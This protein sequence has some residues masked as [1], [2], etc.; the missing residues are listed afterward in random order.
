[1]IFGRLCC[2]ALLSGAAALPQTQQPGNSPPDVAAQVAPELR[3]FLDVFSAVQTKAAGADGESL[4]HMIYEGAIPS[5]LRRLDPHTQFFEPTQF[6]QL[7]QMEASEEKGFGSIVSVLPGQVIFLQIFP[8]TPTSKAG[9]QPGDELVAIN[10]VAIRSLD[11]EQIVQLLTQARQQT[12]AVFL[13]R[14]GSENVLQATLTPEIEDAHTV[15]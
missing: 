14:R 7:K 6:D 12:I 1:M 5:M 9:I 11:P 13:R 15:D 8:G 3:R 2:L 10:N 4:D